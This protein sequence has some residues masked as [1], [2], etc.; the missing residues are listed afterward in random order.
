METINYAEH[1]ISLAQTI[2]SINDVN[3]IFQ[4]QSYVNKLIE[5]KQPKENEFNA[6][7][8]TFE[9]WNEQFDNEE[10]LDNYI[11]EYGMTVREFR[12]MLYN[13]EKGNGMSKQDFF[14]KVNNLK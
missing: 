8:I 9:D 4:I 1:K 13:S 2:F 6:K 5:K 10:K 14:E 12:L 3:K 7:L 11:E